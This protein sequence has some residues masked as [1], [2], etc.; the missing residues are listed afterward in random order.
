M[1][2]I[3]RGWSA[4]IVAGV[5]FLTYLAW[6]IP[7][8]RQDGAEAFI[9]LGRQFVEKSQASPAISARASRYRYDGSVGFDGQWAYYLAVDP[10]NAPSYMDSPAYRYTRILYPLTARVLALGQVDLIPYTLIAVNLLLLGVGTAALA[11]WL[12]RHAMSAWWA[13]IYAF[14]PGAFIALQRDTT[15]VM[16]YG[17]VAVGIYLIDRLPEQPL[18]SAPAFALAILS[19][20]TTAVF[21]IGYTVAILFKPEGNI[22]R[23]LQFGAMAAGPMIAW[24]IFLHQWLGS[25]GFDGHIERV[26]FYGIASWFPW[27]VQQADE[28]RVIVIPA[29]LCGIAAVW[30]LVRGIR[31][32]ETWLLPAN[33]LVL[34]V[35]LERPAFNDIS[36]SGRITLGVAL[37]AALCLPFLVIRIKALIWAAAALW[38]SPMLFWL[39]L[40]T[41]RA[42]L[43]AVRHRLRD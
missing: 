18:W 24:K 25:W 13:A 30:A 4:W 5:V 1:L 3:A 34:V 31:R 37:A 39:A 14:Y 35:F 29:I 23:A 20:E 43:A 40:P 7:T 27:S 19:R 11:L 28:V 9:H 2:T 16:A 42:Y 38:L 22:K 8:V 10:L 36:S 17:L 15:E 21:A 33:V 41:A 32:V 6:T 26:P 12:R